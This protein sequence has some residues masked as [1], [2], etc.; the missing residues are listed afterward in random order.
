MPQVQYTGR[1]NPAH[2]PEGFIRK[3][4]KHYP[5]I[6]DFDIRTFYTR[7]VMLAQPPA[8][9]R[10]L[11]GA[12]ILSENVESLPWWKTLAPTYQ[13]MILSHPVDKGIITSGIEDVN[14]ALRVGGQSRDGISRRSLI[15]V[16]GLENTYIWCKMNSWIQEVTTHDLNIIRSRREGPMRDFNLSIRVI[17]EYGPS[18]YVRP[19]GNAHVRERLVARTVQDISDIFQDQSRK[20]LYGG[21]TLH[22]E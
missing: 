16:P 12:D 6:S 8:G 20:D 22:K 5:G 19:F 18:G 15:S 3:L 11:F 14:R 9:S 17:D 10:A 1:R 4:K 21:V 13:R 7:A 2:D